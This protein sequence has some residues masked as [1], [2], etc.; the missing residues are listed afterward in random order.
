LPHE[1]LPDENFSRL[2]W[3]YASTFSA[4]LRPPAV[5]DETNTSGTFQVFQVF[6]YL[7]AS[8]WRQNQDFSPAAPGFYIALF[9]KKRLD[10]VAWKQVSKGLHILFSAYGN[11]CSNFGISGHRRR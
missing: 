4:R 3:F 5:Y 11:I 10:C 1:R 7:L 9:A 8:G 6:N 2:G